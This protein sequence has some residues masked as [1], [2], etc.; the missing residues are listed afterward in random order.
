ML[1]ILKRHIAFC[2]FL[3]GQVLVP[4]AT[5]EESGPGASF[6]LPHSET[7]LS[8]DVDLSYLQEVKAEEYRR[9]L[10]I[11]WTALR[12][13]KGYLRIAE[14]NGAPVEIQLTIGAGPA[15]L[16]ISG[17]GASV[18]QRGAVEGWR[19]RVCG[20]QGATCL[21]SLPAW[22]TDLTRPCGPQGARCPI[23]F[24]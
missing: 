13:E 6:R 14:G 1:H 24:P 22:P 7:V 3:A 9:G 19:R 21:E 5:A 12:A 20:P 17:S 4:T 16:L 18:Y 15:S 2:A 23:E 10:L 11:S 8:L